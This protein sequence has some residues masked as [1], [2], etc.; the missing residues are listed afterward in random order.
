MDDEKIIPF[1]GYVVSHLNK[2]GVVMIQGKPKEDFKIG[3]SMEVG[4]NCYE[5]VDGHL[6]RVWSEDD[7]KSLCQ[8]LQLE[9]VEIGRTTEVLLGQETKFIHFIARKAKKRRK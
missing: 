8:Y 4:K 3:R 7:I 2:D 6:R 9:V 1:L 5:D